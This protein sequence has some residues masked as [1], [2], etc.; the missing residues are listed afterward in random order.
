MQELHPV[1]KAALA[2]FF[3]CGHASTR[4]VHGVL[5]C[6]DCGVCMNLPE[7]TIAE[8]DRAERGVRS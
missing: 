1:M 3:P 2:P 8:R 4:E 5:K 6:L 7:H